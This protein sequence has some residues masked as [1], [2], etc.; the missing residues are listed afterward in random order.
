MI[1]LKSD[2]GCT[3]HRKER[4]CNNDHDCEILVRVLGAFF[5]RLASSE[6]L[7]MEGVVG[8]RL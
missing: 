3:D 7:Y 1:G 4:M 6:G 5:W 2:S 8:T